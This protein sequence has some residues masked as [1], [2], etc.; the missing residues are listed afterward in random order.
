M[1]LKKTYEDD[2]TWE[3]QYDGRA[4]Y[5]DILDWCRE[6]FGNENVWH[7]NFETIWISGDAAATLF[8]L[9]WS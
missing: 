7:N 5:Q 8:R 3:Y 9:R 4:P 6:S 2:D 1:M